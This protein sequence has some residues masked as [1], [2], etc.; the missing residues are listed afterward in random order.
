LRV[1]A[2]ARALARA[3]RGY[4]I[5]SADGTTTLVRNVILA[6]PPDVAARLLAPLLPEAAALV[7]IRTA[8]IDSTGVV[9]AQG[10]GLPAPRWIGA[11][12]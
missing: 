11:H 3:E 12:R 10:S 9:R 4:A 6:L 7:Q 2:G 8:A 5:T 1:N